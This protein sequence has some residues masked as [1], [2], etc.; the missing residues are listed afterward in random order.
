MLVVIITLTVSLVKVSKEI[1]EYKL[2][3]V[4]GSPN[5]PY[6]LQVYTSI[7]KY[8]KKYKVPKYIAY[9]I[10]YLETTYQGPFDW[11]YHGKLTSYAGAKGPMQIMPK[12]ANYVT[13]KRISKSDL[14][15]NIDLNVHISM[16]LLRNLH[17]RYGDWGVACGYYNTG[18][19]K[20]N[21]Y[22]RFCVSNKEYTKHW[23]KL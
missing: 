10:A 6:S 1:P 13:G 19:P 21:D 17:K 22:A 4:G 7:E 9:N 23:I 18:Y 3:D 20:I 5:S 8:S 14:L 12:T 15:H 16:R 2:E 11:T